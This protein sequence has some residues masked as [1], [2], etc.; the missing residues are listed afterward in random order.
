MLAAG[1]AGSAFNG[2]SIAQKCNV[3]NEFQYAGKVYLCAP[4]IPT[5][6]E[7]PVAPIKPR[8]VSI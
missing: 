6:D 4:L 3:Q 7:E 5:E 1:V 8:P 2:A